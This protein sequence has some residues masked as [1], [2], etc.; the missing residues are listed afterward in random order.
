[1]KKTRKLTSALLLLLL[2]LF[3]LPLTVLARGP[4]E[5]ERDGSLTLRYQNGGRNLSGVRVSLYRAAAVSEAGRFTLTGAFADYAVA[6]NGLPDDAAW[7]AAART[8][9][10]YAEADGAEAL[11]AAV[12]ADDGTV[13]FSE[14]ETGLYLLLA[15]PLRVGDDTYSFQPQLLAMPAADEN[16]QWVYELQ[17]APKTSH[18]H[19]GGDKPGGGDEPG[20]GGPGDGG[21]GGHEDGRRVSYQVVKHWADAEAAGRPG[22]VQAELLRNGKRYDAVTLSEQNDW[23]HVW[24]VPAD[25][26]RWQVVE[27]EVAAPYTVTIERKQN[28]FILTNTLPL[29]PEPEQPSGE[30]L[31]QTGQLWWPVPLLAMAGLALFAAGW[32]MYRR[33]REHERG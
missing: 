16:D 22:A 11:A 25:G 33:G 23:Q 32:A 29:P 17:A 14:L 12:S 15:Q 5:T 8:L 9:A 18:T 31:A 26:A 24:T 27:R 10:A 28:T 4:V 21:D 19:D 3:S 30:K 13:V 1:M 7:Q 6:V 2:L 20:G